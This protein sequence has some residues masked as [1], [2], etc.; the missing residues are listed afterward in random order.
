MNIK[1][2]KDLLERYKNITLEK[3]KNEYDDKIHLYPK[4][5]LQ[6]LTGFG[7]TTTCTLCLAAAELVSSTTSGTY[8]HKCV[9]SINKIN[10]GEFYCLDSTYE[11]IYEAKTIEELYDAIQL[12]IQ[13]LENQIKLYYDQI[14]KTYK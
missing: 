2:A 11:A 7:A 8:C 6:D 5:V 9:H 13:V 1:A 4:H 10:E 12:R 14:N 3:L